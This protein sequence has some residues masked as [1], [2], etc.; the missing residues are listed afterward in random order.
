MSAKTACGFCVDGRRVR[1]DG[2]WTEC[3]Y[4]EGSGLAPMD[5][6]TPAIS[7]RS[8]AIP[9]RGAKQ[10]AVATGERNG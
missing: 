10:R 7:R 2:T 1:R 8:R 6:D 5:D 3:P 9:T 4:C